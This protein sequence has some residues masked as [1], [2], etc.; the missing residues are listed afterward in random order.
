MP[1]PA[2]P[3]PL[4]APS[5]QLPP[6]SP[7]THRPVSCT[8]LHRPWQCW[9]RLATGACPGSLW[10]PRH[11]SFS[12]PGTCFRA[13]PSPRPP[14]LTPQAGPRCWDAAAGCSAPDPPASH[15]LL[16]LSQERYEAAIQRSAK[17]TWAEI[18]QQRWS[19]AGALHQSS[20]R[21]KDGES[22]AQAHAWLGTSCLGSPLACK[23]ERGGCGILGHVGHRLS[24][25]G[26]ALQ[27]AVPGFTH[28]SLPPGCCWE[29]P[30]EGLGR[31]AVSR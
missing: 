28:R 6:S 13:S 31:F 23:D 26:Q 15:P 22:G 17:K 27:S 5:M 16:S 25:A 20:S 24:A 11:G 14:T 7:C 2:S 30:R 4:H 21:H 10:S 19:W 8:S 1:H 12:F 18:R 3:V 9:G 29:W